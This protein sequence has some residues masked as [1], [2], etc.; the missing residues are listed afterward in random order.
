MDSKSLIVQNNLSLP[1]ESID[2]LLSLYGRGSL[3][4]L[5]PD[6]EAGAF[7]LFACGN[8]LDT[9]AIKLSVPKEVLYFTALHYNWHD[10]H[11]I[12]NGHDVNMAKELQVDLAK[13]L[14]VATSIALK[15]ELGDVISGKIKPSQSALIPKTP[16]AL[17]ETMEFIDS[18]LNPASSAPQGSII[19]ENVTINNN[20]NLTVT[21]EK[22]EIK[23]VKFKALSDS[24]G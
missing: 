22:P 17:K 12:L 11:K 4:P 24:V 13:T 5:S 8:D 19:A 15:Q 1:K 21:E 9:I 18:V 2:K 10:K 23:V 7:L 14:L 3:H 6:K 16:K 20:N